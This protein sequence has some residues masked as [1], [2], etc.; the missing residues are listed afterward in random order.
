MLQGT[1]SEEGEVLT[2]RIDFMVTG[3][4]KRIDGVDAVVAYIDDFADDQLVESEIAFYAQDDEG[5]VWYLGEYPEEYQ[6]GEFVTAKP[7]IH[8]LEGAKAGMKMKASPKVGEVP[9]FQGWGP[10]VDWN[11]FAFVAETGMSD[12][13]SSDCYE[14]VLM[15][16]ETS[17]DEQGAFQLKYY[18][19]D[20]GNHRVGWEGNDATREELELV[21]R[22][23]LDDEGLE[24][25][26]EK[27]RALDRRGSEIN[28]M[29][30]ETS[31]V[32]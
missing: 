24:Q 32:N 11:D 21:E 20:I 22:V 23:A 12:C 27:A 26:N 9:Y 4:T 14:D 16:R 28:Q 19:P 10:A 25:L 3:L 31:P 6:D 2:R 1:T 8:G 5:N 30:S 13:V 15:V 29:Y 18:A 17:L 7:W